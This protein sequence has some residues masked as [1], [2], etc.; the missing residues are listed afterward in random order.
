MYFDG[1]DV[2]LADNINEYIDGAAI[3]ASG[4]L[5]LSTGGD[6]S[7]AEL[8]GADEDVFGFTASSIGSNTAGS[9]DTDLFFDGSKFNLS[10]MNIDALSFT[11]DAF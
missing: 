6:F 8:S 5:F 9:F 3:D 7:V 4:K 11:V 2:G 10:N 1:S